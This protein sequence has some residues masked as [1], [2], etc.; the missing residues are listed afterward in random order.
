MLLAVIKTE[1]LKLR[2]APVW[3][4]FLIL[5]LLAAIMGTFNYAQNMGILKKAWFSLWTQHT[6]F[7][8]FFFLPALIGVLCAY[9]WRLEHRENNWNKLM[10]QPVPASSIYLGKLA[11]SAAL[12]ALTQIWAGALYWICGRCAGLT[13]VP[14][15][16][17]MMWL[18]LGSL[19]GIAIASLQSLLS[20]VIKSFAIP[21]GVALV[22]GIA[23]MLFANYGYGLYCPYA[24]LAMGMDAN[25]KGYIS[26]DHT[27]PYLL[28]CLLFTAL[29]TCLAIVLLKRRDVDTN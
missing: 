10:T 2:R 22:G 7:S 18:T 4:A 3:I 6:L 21:V 5:P 13:G 14:P 16:E 29:F 11:V 28:S 23:G 19:G 9:Q 26:I 27:L 1:L 17:L 25:G 12:V 20:M 24:L 8:S 15:K